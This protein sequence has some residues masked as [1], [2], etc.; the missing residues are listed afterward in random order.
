MRGKRSE[1]KNEKISKYVKIRRKRKVVNIM[2]VLTVG[3]ESH[4]ELR[5]GNN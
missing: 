5:S 4:Y 3:G 1:P 2:Y